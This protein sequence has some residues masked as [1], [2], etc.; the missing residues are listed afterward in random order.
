MPAQQ[1]KKKKVEL[2]Y[3]IAEKYVELKYQQLDFGGE[4]LCII[5]A[6]ATLGFYTLAFLKT[7][8]TVIPD[9]LAM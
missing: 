5:S 9:G 4:P 6:F 7:I 8:K 1:N 3:P 2:C